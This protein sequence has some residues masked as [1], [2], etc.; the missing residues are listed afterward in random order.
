M[1]HIFIQPDHLQPQTP[2]TTPPVVF[3]PGW[4]FDGRIT[5]LLDRQARSW[6]YPATMLDPTTLTNDL[7]AFLN[8]KA[9]DRIELKGWSMGGYLAL[10]FARTYPDRAATLELIGTRCQWPAAEIDAII[11]ELQAD[12]AAF[13][14]PFIGNVFSARS[15]CTGLL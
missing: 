7:F 8:E 1:H 2:P 14:T 15:P 13:Y 4:G 9:I 3:L 11:N 6:I 12:P 10:D 5:E